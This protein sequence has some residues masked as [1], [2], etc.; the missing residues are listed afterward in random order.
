MG[1]AA[2][3][4]PPSHPRPPE[5]V[6]GVHAMGMDRDIHPVDDVG[7]YAAEADICPQI[8][9]QVGRQ[10]WAGPPGA[11]GCKQDG[12][13]PALRDGISDGEFKA[14]QDAALVKRFIGH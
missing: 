1:S 13:E 12:E 6:G 11:D 14:Q 10:A 7:I 5:R 9:G 2:L 4:P 3:T 8:S